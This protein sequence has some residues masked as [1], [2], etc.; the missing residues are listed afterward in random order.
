MKPDG[1]IQVEMLMAQAFFGALGL[2]HLQDPRAAGD[3]LRAKRCFSNMLDAKAGILIDLQRL[4]RT[5]LAFK[6]VDE[7]EEAIV[8]L[9]R[10]LDF[11][12]RTYMGESVAASKGIRL[13]C[14][15]T[16]LA[17]AEAVAEIDRTGR[18]PDTLL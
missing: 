10:C 15:D 12:G 16:I 3:A 1:Y 18:L 14:G 11:L 4:R 13:Q 7:I 17:V 9:V 6:P 2:E 5:S 8:D